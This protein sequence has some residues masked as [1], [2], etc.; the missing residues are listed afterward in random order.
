MKKTFVSIAWFLFFLTMPSCKKFVLIPPPVN[1]VTNQTLFTSDATATAAV[2]GMYSQM[3]NDPSQFTN[4]FV[5]FYAGMAADELSYN[6][7]GSNQEFLTNKITLANHSLLQ[8]SFWQPA[9]TYIYTANAILEGLAFSDQVTPSVKNQLLGEAKFIRSFCYFYL[10]NLFGAVPLVTTTDYR[11]TIQLERTPVPVIYTQMEDDLEEAQ[12]LLGSDYSGPE[13]IRPNR[14]A[15]ASL[16][17][18]VH[19]YRE[20]WEKAEAEASLV[21]NSARYSLA[22][23]KDVFLKNS[24]EAIWQLRP[25]NATYNTHE[26]KAILPISPAT[27][28]AYVLSQTLINA[29]EDGDSR[30]IFWDTA[31]IYEMQRVELP[32]K[33]KVYNPGEPL[34]EY[35]TVLRL[36][37]QYLIRAEASAHQNKLREA[38]ADINLLR[39]RAGLNDTTATTQKDMLAI[40]EHERW[41]ELFAEW[42]HRWFDLKRTGRAAS[43]LGALKNTWTDAAMLWPVPQG[44]INAN[45]ALTQNPGY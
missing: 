14:W 45:P 22:T 33:Y 8:M 12:A 34:S 17:A 25:V 16:L 28:P 35:Y 6:L 3:M 4:G 13:K 2:T 11:A 18:R 21:I 19:L 30:K 9:Y 24:Q 23:L 31:L 39:G 32:Y 43:V 10:V 26:A 38:T 29:F 27:P 1:Q 40:I 5:T 20:E 42:G 7:P 44:E 41:V 15:A 37:E 36:A